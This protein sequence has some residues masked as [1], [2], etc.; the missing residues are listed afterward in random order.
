MNILNKHAKLE[1]KTI[2]TFEPSL[3]LFKILKVSKSQPFSEQEQQTERMFKSTLKD[4][5]GKS[6]EPVLFNSNTIDFNYS[7]GEF[8][9]HLTKPIFFYRIHANYYLTNGVLKNP[10]LAY[11]Q[12]INYGQIAS[13]AWNIFH[14]EEERKE[15]EVPVADK[16]IAKAPKNANDQVT[17]KGT[18]DELSAGLLLQKLYRQ[19]PVIGFNNFELTRI[20]S[21]RELFW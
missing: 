9:N 10:N 7:L 2:G 15:V 16:Q 17:K 13:Q 20:L 3:P 12:G 6:V 11:E 4:T 5:L 18:F 8:F 14:A 19:D 1:I 21:S